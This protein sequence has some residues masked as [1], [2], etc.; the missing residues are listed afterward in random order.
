MNT[1]DI[2]IL[3][4]I[5]VF[6]IK[7]LFRGAI[8]ETIGLVGLVVSLIAGIKLMSNVAELLDRV[9]DIPPGFITLL[10]F[11]LVFVSLQIAAQVLSFVLHKIVKFTFMRPIEKLV[12]GIIGL[13]KGGVITSLLVLLVSIIPFSD[14]I[15]PNRDQSLLYE[16]VKKLAPRMFNM[17]MAVV[18]GSKSFYSELKESIERSTN[19]VS[20]HTDGFL[21]SF[22]AEGSRSNSRSRK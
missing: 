13:A 21:E 14:Q 20:K 8:N 5:A 11:L 10:S 6:T 19:K 18:P 16:P 12:G 7:G 15:L 2:A 3:G 1:I 22:K 17:M 9:L 4:I